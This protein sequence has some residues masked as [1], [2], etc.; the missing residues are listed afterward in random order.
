MTRVIV[1]RP[2]PGCSATT[3]LA[4]E[5][6]LEAVGHPLSEI[7]P[8]QWQ[9]PAGAFDG[10]LAGSAN[11]FRH[12]GPLVDKLVDMPVY[13]VGETT[14]AAAGDR[15]FRTA[16]VGPGGLQSVLDGLAGQHLKL[17][18]IAGEDHLDLD[19][20]EGIE[21]AEVIAY[22]AEMRPIPAALA[23]L[24][25]QYPVVV[26]HSATTARHFAAET[27]RLGIDRGRIR[28]AAL[29]PRIAAAAGDGWGALSAA[30]APND[31][32]L[33]ALARDLCHEPFQG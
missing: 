7:V 2:E 6:G 28:L 10:V 29:G 14:A 24:L 19:P 3:R 13:A 16:S 22:R 27:E 30:P 20:P 26:L 23:V 21:V 5:F 11:A 1:V 18:R 9:M 12:G 32:A 8:I 31:P 15:G 4:Q 17:L 33:L 25:E